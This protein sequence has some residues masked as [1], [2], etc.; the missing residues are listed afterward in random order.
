MIGKRVF[1][2]MILSRAASLAACSD[3]ASFTYSRPAVRKTLETLHGFAS[4]R[5]YTDLL[6]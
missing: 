1:T 5:L 3:T 2:G 6:R 4:L